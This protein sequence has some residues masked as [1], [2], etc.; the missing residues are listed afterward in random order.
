MVLLP[1]KVIDMEISQTRDQVTAPAVDNVRARRQ[2]AQAVEIDPSDDTVLH[3]HSAAR[4]H[5]G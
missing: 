5:L 2:L 4:Q 3:H 1:R